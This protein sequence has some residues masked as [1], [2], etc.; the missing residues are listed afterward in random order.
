MIAKASQQLWIA[1]KGSQADLVRNIL[2]H[3]PPPDVDRRHQAEEMGEITTPLVQAVRNDNEDIVR[4]LLNAG[5]YID[6]VAIFEA[7]N[8]AEM[9]ELLMMSKN[10][11]DFS[12]DER[13]SLTAQ[14]PSEA[15]AA[16]RASLSRTT[17]AAIAAR[18]ATARRTSR[19]TEAVYESI[20]KEFDANVETQRTQRQKVF[21][22]SVTVMRAKPTRRPSTAPPASSTS[23]SARSATASHRPS[24]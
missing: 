19:A 1:A 13:D 24:H 10:P 4:L 8:N 15:Q 20:S 12:Q 5:V 14:S 23:T 9:M 11:S 3:D 21:Q 22:R 6:S 7:R 18:R 16:R 17:A 2:G